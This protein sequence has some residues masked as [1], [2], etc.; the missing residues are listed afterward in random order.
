MKFRAKS[1]RKTGCYSL[2]VSKTEILRYT[3]PC[4]NKIAA[5]VVMSMINESVETT[6]SQ[7]KNPRKYPTL[8]PHISKISTVNTQ[9]QVMT[10]AS[11]VGSFSIGAYISRILSPNKANTVISVVT[12]ENKAFSEIVDAKALIP[13]I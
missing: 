4:P 5:M 1:Y 6:S 2:L 10:I 3:C 7:K 11:N 9:M 12:A 13:K 8:P